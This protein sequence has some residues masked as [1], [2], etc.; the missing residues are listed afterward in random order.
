ML[1]MS[2]SLRAHR[3][4][5]RDADRV[6]LIVWIGTSHLVAKGVMLPVE[7]PVLEAKGAIDNLEGAHS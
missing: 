2:S 6:A 1:F 4:Y 3:V 7:Y 5:V